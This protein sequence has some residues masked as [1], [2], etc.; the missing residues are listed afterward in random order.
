M[1]HAGQHEHVPGRCDRAAG[2]DHHALHPVGQFGQR[3]DRR[4]QEPLANVH[5]GRTEADQHELACR[6]QL[7]PGKPGALR[8]RGDRGADE[9]G[10]PTDL[11]DQRLGGERQQQVRGEAQVTG[12]GRIPVPGTQPAQQL[13]QPTL[14]LRHARQRGDQFRRGGRRGHP[15]QAE[16]FGDQGAR[17]RLL[18]DDQHLRCELPHGGVHEWHQVLGQRDDELL[19]Q[20]LQGG[21]PAQLRRPVDD[22]VLRQP[23]GAG[24]QQRVRTEQP[25]DGLG[26]AHPGHLVALVAQLRGDPDQGVDVPDQW[27]D[28][29]QEPRHATL[30]ASTAGAVPSAAASAAS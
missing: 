17:D 15:R 29:E 6:I 9:A 21:E 23:F 8:P 5:I 28:D 27:R 22:D 20:E 2:I 18:V 16:A 1:R 19:P 30:S 7:V 14:Q 24:Q 13:V 26:R 12:G 11:A 10:G 4:G 25:G 3:L